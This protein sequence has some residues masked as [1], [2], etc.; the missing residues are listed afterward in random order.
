LTQPLHRLGAHFWAGSTR[1]A[2]GDELDACPA[3]SLSL[4]FNLGFAQSTE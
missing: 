1:G 4:V 3:R 2:C